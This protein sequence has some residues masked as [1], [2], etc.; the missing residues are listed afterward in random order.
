MR[1]DKFE[2]NYLYQMMQ[3]PKQLMQYKMIKGFSFSDKRQ[4]VELFEE[5][6]YALNE[7][8]GKIEFK[9][10]NYKVLELLRQS[11]YR[12]ESTGDDGIYHIFLY[13]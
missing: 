1:N 13:L 4:L 12:V 2:K 10:L 11:G 9:Y 6:I 8:K 5:A 7:G 3:T